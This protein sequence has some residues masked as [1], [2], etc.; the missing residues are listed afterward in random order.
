MVVPRPGV[1]NGNLYQVVSVTDN[2]LLVPP[3]LSEGLGRVM[4]EAMHCG[5]PVVASNV[6]GIPD[7]V[8]DGDTGYLVAPNDVPALAGAM[9]RAF[10]DPVALDAMAARARES[11]VNVASRDLFLDG[12]RR[13]IVAAAGRLEAAQR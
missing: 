9:L 3:S 6:G 5:T 13:L 10:S 1:R 2:V 12:H 7:V 8:T 11:A 4:I